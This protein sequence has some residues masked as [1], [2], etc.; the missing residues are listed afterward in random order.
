MAVSAYHAGLDRR[1][2]AT[3]ED[4][5]DLEARIRS[6]ELAFQMQSHAPDAVDLSQETADTQKLYGLDDKETA[7]YGR[8]LLMAR[9][10][11]ERG[12]RFINIIYASWDHHS[13][14]DKE[15]AYNATVVDQPIAALV[16]DLK[17][18]GLLDE[19]LVVWGGEFGRAPGSPRW[20]AGLTVA[21]LVS[22]G[23]RRSGVGLTPARRRLVPEAGG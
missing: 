19:T 10:L 23:G 16:M 8:N 9:R 20:D 3:R 1:H 4:N 12:V 6:F 7:S 22:D 14:L 11:V 15:L 17:Q 13:N 5:T 21:R 2:A 18:R